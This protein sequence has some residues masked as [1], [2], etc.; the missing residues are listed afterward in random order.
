[1]MLLS[2][3]LLAHILRPLQLRLTPAFR[4]TQSNDNVVILKKSILQVN[5]APGEHVEVNEWECQ[6]VDFK[7]IWKCFL[8]SAVNVIA[9]LYWLTKDPLLLTWQLAQQ[10]FRL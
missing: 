1:M 5:D 3:M 10:F 9:S 4:K 2:L 8:L 6:T 7:K